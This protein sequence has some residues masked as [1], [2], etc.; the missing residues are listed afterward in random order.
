M[1]KRRLGSNCNDIRIADMNITKILEF[2]HMECL[3]CG[4]VAATLYG[5]KEFPYMYVIKA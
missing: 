1:L 2:A 5:C 3:G 4:M